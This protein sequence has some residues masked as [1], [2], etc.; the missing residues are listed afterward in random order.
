ME[1][2]TGAS[3]ARV[4]TGLPFVAVLIHDE[5]SM[6][7]ALRGEL[8]VATAEGAKAALFM[9]ENAAGGRPV[10]ADLREL[11]FCGSVGLSLL[12]EAGERA[13]AA[14]RRFAVIPGPI[15]RHVFQLV[16]IGDQL[17]I[18]EEP[19]PPGATQA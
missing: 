14:G 18:V 9:G 7:V 13:R 8:D 1:H 16:A 11:T 17:E 5:A 2:A 4:P 3:A 12:L 6:T 19:G 15:V 10:V